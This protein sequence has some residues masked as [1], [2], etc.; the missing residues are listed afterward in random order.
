MNEDI[1]HDSHRIGLRKSFM[2]A[3]DFSNPVNR[4]ITKISISW[5]NFLEGFSIVLNTFTFKFEV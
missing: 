1:S 2:I 3:G 5:G 4:P